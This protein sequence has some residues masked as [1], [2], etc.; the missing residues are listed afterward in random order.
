MRDKG[1]GT[2]SFGFREV[3]AGEKA[4]LVRSVFDS[5]APKYDL[6][7]DLM[8]AGVHRLWKAVLIDRLNPR[9]GETLLDVAGGTGD[10]AA[11]F[12]ARADDRRNSGAAPHARAIVA[13]VN[14]AMLKE[15]RARRRKGDT[16]ARLALL[17]ADAENLPLPDQ[18]VDAYTAAFGLRN[19][20]NVSRALVEARRTLKI[21]GRFFCL[22]FSHLATEGLQKLYD[23][24]SFSVIPWLGEKIA[25]DRD[26]YHYLV[27][28]IRRFPNQ[29]AFAAMV[30]E[31]GFSCVKYE[32]LSAGIA[33]I[34]S[35]W[36]T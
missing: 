27:E 16:A 29:E 34:H 31:A 25:K 17:C 24:Y 21:G 8:S 3:P 4:G 7:N 22:E 15:A 9:P 19:V 5:V 26:S 1:T 23:A 12:L 2:A 33:A 28:S 11:A 20:T 13:D 36:R 10:I 14:L 32:N 6:M 35:G 30:R 18:S